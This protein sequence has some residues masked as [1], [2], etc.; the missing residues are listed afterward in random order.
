MAPRNLRCLLPMMRRQCRPRRASPQRRHAIPNKA[1]VAVVVT[2]AAA[3]A[4][5]TPEVARAI[6]RAV[7]RAVVTA[8]ASA[9]FE[10]IIIIIIIAARAPAV[11]PR[12]T[13]PPDATTVPALDRD[14]GTLTAAVAVAS[15][16]SRRADTTPKPSPVPSVAGRAST[17]T[18]L[19]WP[20]R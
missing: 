4:V 7:V 18:R 17:H 16:R 13:A 10:A 19:L 6:A 14:P 11:A 20:P 9:V 12:S 3:V 8:S 15:V 1:A 2:T 5:A